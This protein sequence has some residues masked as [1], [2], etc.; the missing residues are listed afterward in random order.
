SVWRFGLGTVGLVIIALALPGSRNLLA[1]LRSHGVEIVALSLFGVTTAYLMFHWSLDFASVPQV[2]TMVTTAPIFVAIVNLKV[3]HEPVSP[4]KMAGGAA[5]LLGVALLL[6]DGYLA[7]LAGSPRSLY[8][9]LLALG[10][11]VALAVYMV[12]IRPIIA[13]YGALRVSAL[14]LSI[15]SIGLWVVVGIG[16]GIWVDPSNLFERPPGEL[17]ALLVLALYN[18][19][20]TQFLWIGGLAAVPDVTRG[21]YLFFLKPVLAAFL[22]LVFLGQDLSLYEGLAIALICGG[23]ALEA[24]WGGV[25]KGKSA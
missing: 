14:S 25:F 8:G 9:V 13:A 1:P 21:M 23:V 15:G 17:T 11:A 12:R 7:R 22:A 3:N 16:W 19:T 6:T 10:C 18:T 24:F 4:G 5:A 2:A 20:I